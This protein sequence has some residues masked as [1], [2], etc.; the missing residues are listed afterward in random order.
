[1]IYENLLVE[2]TMEKIAIV[3]L[4]RPEKLNAL[5]DATFDELDHCFSGLQ[6]NDE[7]KCVIITGSG[8]KAF[9]AGADIL[10]L[11]RQNKQSGSVFSSKGQGVFNKIEQLGKPVIAAINGFALGGGCELAL[12]CHIRY[13]SDNAKFGQPEINLGIIPGY[14]GTQR[15]ARLINVGRALELILS[16]R[17]ID[18]EE[19]LKIGLVNKVF[20]KSELMPKTMELASG[21]ASKSSGILGYALSATLA[22]NSLDLQS[23]LDL[24][25]ELFGIACGTND[26]QEGTSA[27][28]EKR[29]PVFRE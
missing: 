8:E 4:N 21:I 29:K 28:L 5:N 12:S 15:L 11:N 1:M 3:T 6:V 26:F 18:A 14:G 16:G 17:M 27:F 10:E 23:G 24:E 13:A 20:E 7:V 9:V 2:I 25:S 19:A 22:T